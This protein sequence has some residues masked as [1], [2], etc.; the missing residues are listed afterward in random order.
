MEVGKVR[1]GGKEGRWS[2]DFI[3]W[4]EAGEVLKPTCATP[5]LMFLKSPC[6]ECS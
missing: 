5:W 6:L 1:G 2:N 3:V 4:I